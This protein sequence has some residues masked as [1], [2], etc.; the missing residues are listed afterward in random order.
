MRSVRVASLMH[1][2]PLQDSGLHDPVRVNHEPSLPR[3]SAELQD[4]AVLHEI[5]R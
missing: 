5:A 4:S 2:A 1:V 3:G